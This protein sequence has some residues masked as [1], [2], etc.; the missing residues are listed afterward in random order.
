MRPS[1]TMSG[2]ATFVLG[3]L[4]NRI[5]VPVAE[6]ELAD[7]MADALTAGSLLLQVGGSVLA[8]YGRWRKGD[9]SALGVKKDGPPWPK[10]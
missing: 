2:I 4:L 1:V 6:D 7:T 3:T 5:G 9:V 10:V 8:W